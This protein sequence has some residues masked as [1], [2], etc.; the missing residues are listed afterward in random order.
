[1]A[2]PLRS[3]FAGA[4]WHVTARGNERQEI[5]RDAQDKETFLR[6]LGSVVARFGW[7]LHGYVLM[8]NH[9]HLLVE[10]PR[11]TLSDG[12]RQLGSVYSQA[13]NRRWER[14]GHLFQG[15]FFSLHVQRE[16]HLL[17]LLRYIALNPVRAGLVREPGEWPWSSYRAT[18]GSAPRPEW[19][20]TGWTLS[21]FAGRERATRAFGRFVATASGYAPWGLVRHQVLLGDDDFVAGFRSRAASQASTR[22]VPARQLRIASTPLDEVARRLRPYL[23][24]GRLRASA[25]ADRM[26]AALVLRDDSLAT[27]SQIG[28]EAGL[29][30][31]GARSLVDRARRLLTEKPSAGRRLA[32]L[33]SIAEGPRKR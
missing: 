3:D 13:F 12:M 26:L 5:F 27:Y 29:T 10:T 4:L 20:E 17:E 11:P 7:T 32:E 15:R 30:T 8:P 25:G 1:M 31:W 22:G 6:V 23:Q 21:Q 33:R 9:Y 2:R 24:P 16:S 14:V 18:I 28:E 19:L